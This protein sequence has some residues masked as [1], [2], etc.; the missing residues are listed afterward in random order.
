MNKIITEITPLSEKDFFYLIDR[1]KDEF[2]FPIHRHSEYE[3]NFVENCR[4]VRR[5]VGDSIETLGD[6]DLCLLGHGI[7]HAWEQGECASKPIREI[8]IQFSENLFGT[9]M[10]NKTQ[11]A[12]IKK[13]LN[14]CSK[15]IAFP[16]PTIMRVYN[17]LDK[18]TKA[19][20]GFNQ[21]IEFLKL[22]HDLSVDEG[23]RVLSSSAF[24]NAAPTSDS[25]R[26]QKIQSYIY[27]HYKEDLTLD[28]LSSMVGMTPTSFSRFFKLRTGKNLSDYI[29]DIRIGHASRFLT[30]ST[31]SIAEICYE[32][33][34]NN[35]SNFN[36]MFRKKKNCT[37]K[38]FRE[39]Y[40]RH[41]KII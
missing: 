15:G 2:T 32:C 23:Q 25:R 12:S 14:N 26:I 24:A 8:T 29:T 27:E 33:G 11:M 16:M 38:E 17:T 31:T 6:Y 37:P 5:I 10:L 28:L 19:D 30:D 21:M 4:G 35:I 22:L 34:F 36:R 13:L 3:L 40:K 1:T 41:L 7:Q 9:E 20:S 18:I 39:Y